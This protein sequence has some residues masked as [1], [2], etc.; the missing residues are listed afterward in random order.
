MSDVITPKE[1]LTAYER[2]ELP[3]FD[4]EGSVKVTGN[5]NGMKL[6]TAAQLEE[7]Q[8]QAHEEG[9]EQGRQAGQEAGYS[10]GAHQVAEEAARLTALVGS[11]EQALAEVNQQISQSLL[12]LALELA[13]KMVQQTLEVRPELLLE[14]ISNAIGNLPHFNPSA[15]LVMHPD[16]AAIV[17]ERMGEQLAHSGWKIFE[18]GKITRG[19][20][21]VETANSQIDATVETRWKRI[22]AN[23]GQESTW[24]K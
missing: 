4:P 12:N 1:K 14:V 21:R 15:H 23:M 13:Q 5:A 11:M 20:V 8:Q 19:G 22:T 9:F 7:I 2:W 18:D 24:L 17:R 16:D 6:P 10:Q 3:S